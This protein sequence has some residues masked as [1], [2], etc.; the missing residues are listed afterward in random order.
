MEPFDDMYGANPDDLN[1]ASRIVAFRN[2]KE[3]DF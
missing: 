1:N 2:S 3:T